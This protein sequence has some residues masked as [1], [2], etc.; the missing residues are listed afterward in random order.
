VKLAES[1]KEAADFLAQEVTPAFEEVKAQLEKHGRIVE[2]HVGADQA[3][4]KV[5]HEGHE[6][7]DYT[8]VCNVR[9]GFAGAVPVTRGYNA[10]QHYKAQGYFR[11]GAQDY[12]CKDLK[13]D[14][15]IQNLLGN[16]KGHVTRSRI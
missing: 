9:P 14:D 5:R 15:I 12:G 7:L 4:M 11:S 6:E 8:V 3:H 13:K 16:Y 1:E 10:G 2:F